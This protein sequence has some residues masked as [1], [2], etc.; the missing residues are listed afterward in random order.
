MNLLDILAIFLFWS[1]SLKSLEFS[2]LGIKID[3]KVI[4]SFIYETIFDE[5]HCNLTLFDN[6]WLYPKTMALETTH[7]KKFEKSIDNHGIIDWQYEFYVAWM[8]RTFHSIM[9][10][11]GTNGLSFVGRDA[12]SW[13]I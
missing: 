4:F 8:A 9:T 2:L 7:S 12:H 5:D 1:V 3:R 13:V 10:T 6:F 11:S